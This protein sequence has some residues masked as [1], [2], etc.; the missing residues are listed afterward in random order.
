METET[1]TEERGLLASW[2]E[3][4][5]YLG[6]DKR[7]CARWEKALGLPVHRL[8]GAP[9]SRVFAYKE[10]LDGWRRR[11]LNGHEAQDPPRAG[12]RGLFRPAVVLPAAVI[13][14]GSAL[15]LTALLVA[16]RVPADFR[17]SGSSLIV[18]NEDGRE[19]WRFHTGL[20]NLEGDARYRTH[21]FTRVPEPTEPGGFTT[22][23]LRFKDID[24]DG[25]VEVLFSIQ[26]ENEFGEGDLYCFDARGRRRWRFHSGRAMTFG[27]TA[28]SPDYRIYV[29]DAEDLD[30]DGKL[31]VFVVSA[32]NNDFPTQLM[33]LDCRG[34][35]R[36]EFWN[37]GQVADYLFRDI[38]GDGRKE[39]LAS[40]VNNEYREGYFMVLGASRIGGGSPQM[41][42]R[43]TSPDV[44]PG[45]ELCYVRVP[46][47]DVAKLKR[48]VEAVVEIAV[49]GDKRIQL[50]TSP[51]GLYFTLG[52]DLKPSG[53]RSSH[54]FEQMR[55]DAVRA[56][57]L[58]GPA[59]KAY[60]EALE[61]GLLYWNGREWTGTPSWCAPA[62]R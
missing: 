36:G 19:L 33:L 44:G 50:F 62:I 7:T 14:I 29:V 21:S 6:V 5:A 8:E 59:D 56:G 61:R 26:T 31:E 37:S 13:V 18:L 43:Y 16:D 41:D 60:F 30:G 2:K 38:N 20:D 39:I 22:P 17:I 54:Y 52:S 45:S 53:V 23:W 28:F 9:R 4:S 55:A 58:K 34:G 47:S 40:G 12:K 25:K 24:A 46:R 32:H 11:R 42:P 10:E 3:I 35:A 57:K 49:L 51:G 48:P 1:G 15:L 27:D